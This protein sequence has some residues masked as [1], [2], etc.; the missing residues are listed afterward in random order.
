[1]KRLLIPLLAALAL[2]TAVN[3]SPLYLSCSVFQQ[4]TNDK[5][6]KDIKDKTSITEFTLNEEDQSGTVYFSHSGLTEKLGLVNFQ[7]ESIIMGSDDGNIS[8][9]FEISRIDGS[10][11]RTMDL[12]G[13]AIKIQ[14]KGTCKKSEPK[15][16][17]F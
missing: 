14:S 13:G 10:Y 3:A 5:S 12:Y 15:K 4:R 7:S 16:T 6:W 2:P 8:S 9:T 1:M 11:L 17:L